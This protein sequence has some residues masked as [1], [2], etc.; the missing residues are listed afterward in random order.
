MSSL[1]I[2]VFSSSFKEKLKY[3]IGRLCRCCCCDGRQFPFQEHYTPS[4]NDSNMKRDILYNKWSGKWSLLS[5]GT[6]SQTQ[7]IYSIQ[8]NI[9]IEC[10]PKANKLY[11]FCLVFTA[12]Y[13]F[14]FDRIKFCSCREVLRGREHSI[15]WFSQC[16]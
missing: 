12:M 15:Y 2:Y 16:N 7:Y 3:K 14:E 1:K 8:E 13:I 11:F 9:K 5:V 4:W 10:S 6:S